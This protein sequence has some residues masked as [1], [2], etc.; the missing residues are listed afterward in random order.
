MDNEILSIRIPKF[1]HWTITWR[2]K[3]HLKLDVG[4]QSY[5][6]YCSF[7]IEH[8]HHLNAQ[9]FHPHYFFEL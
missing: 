9:F 7:C 3:K 8:Y 4:K 5:N 6:G 2:Y 1:V